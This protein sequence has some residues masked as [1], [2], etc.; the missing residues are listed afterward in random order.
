MLLTRTTVMTTWHNLIDLKETFFHTGVV[1][2]LMPY[3]IY[4]IHIHIHVYISVYLYKVAAPGFVIYP[5]I[6]DENFFF[7]GMDR[8]LCESFDEWFRLM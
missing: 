7:F 1:Y 3:T 8:L 5:S 2:N 6:S 4:T